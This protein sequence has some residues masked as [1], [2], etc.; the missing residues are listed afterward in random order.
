MEINIFDV[1]KLNDGRIGTVKSKQGK[2]VLIELANNEE[3]KEK[4]IEIN[5]IDIDK[6]LYKN[7]ITPY[8]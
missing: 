4:V 1:I 7:K 8:L 6:I 2:Q 5:K 3:N